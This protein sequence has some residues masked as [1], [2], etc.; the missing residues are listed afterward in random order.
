MADFDWSIWLPVR[1]NQNYPSRTWYHLNKSVLIWF[2][3]CDVPTYS[4]VELP[5]L[6]RVNQ[7]PSLGLH[8]CT[9]VDQLSLFVVNI[10]GDLVMRYRHIPTGIA[11]SPFKVWCAVCMLKKLWKTL[12]AKFCRYFFL[13]FFLSII[14]LHLLLDHMYLHFNLPYIFCLLPVISTYLLMIWSNHTHWDN[15]FK[16]LLN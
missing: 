8:Q 1:L 13:G 3:C 14:Y 16:T 12:Q 2:T 15:L 11:S 5:S 10:A 6:R 4:D 7:V 9:K